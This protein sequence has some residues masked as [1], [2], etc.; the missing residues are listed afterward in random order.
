MTTQVMLVDAVEHIIGEQINAGGELD[1]VI[2]LLKLDELAAEHGDRPL[3][4]A[5]GL[6]LLTRAAR[7][8]HTDSPAAPPA[9]EAAA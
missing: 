9:L 6:A 2:L 3:R 8:S 1:V 4:Q 7:M 5:L